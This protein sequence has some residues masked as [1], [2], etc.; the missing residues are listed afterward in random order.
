MAT[1]TVEWFNDPKRYGFITRASTAGESSGRSPRA[2]PAERHG[3]IQTDG[4]RFAA[5]RARLRGRR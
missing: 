4:V 1:G 3:F 5:R 2:H